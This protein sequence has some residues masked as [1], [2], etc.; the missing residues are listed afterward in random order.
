[1]PRGKTST[2][3]EFGLSGKV[4][5]APLIRLRNSAHVVH[6]LSRLG[7][8]PAPSPAVS[9]APD[10][11]LWRQ[12]RDSPVV[13]RVLRL[14]AHLH[15]AITL[16][17]DTSLWNGS[18]V[19]IINRGGD[20]GRVTNLARSLDRVQLPYTLASAV[21]KRDE[22]Q[23]IGPYARIIGQ[24][25]ISRHLSGPS[26]SSTHS[27]LGG[28]GGGLAFAR[29]VLTGQHHGVGNDRGGGGGGVK[30]GGGGGGDSSWGGG[31]GAP[32]QGPQH[33]MLEHLISHGEAWAHVVQQGIPYALI[34]DDDADIS[35]GRFRAEF[36]RT[37]RQLKL[38]LFQ[39]AAQAVL[40]EE[41]VALMHG[42]GYDLSAARRGGSMER[43]RESTTGAEDA[44]RDGHS[45]VA[46]GQRGEK[47]LKWGE[48]A[49]GNGLGG[50]GGGGRSGS[51]GHVGPTGHAGPRVHAS[52]A[53]ARPNGN[54]HVSSAEPHGHVGVATTRASAGPPPGPPRESPGFDV[55][56]LGRYGQVD[57][58]DL[59]SIGARLA[60]SHHG[61]TLF[62]YLVTLEGAKRLLQHMHADEAGLSRV[63]WG[64]P[65]L[66]RL[67]ADPELATL[68]PGGTSAC[69]HRSATWKLHMERC[70][71][72]LRTSIAPYCG[73]GASTFY[74]K[75][76]PD[77]PTL[78]HPSNPPP[79]HGKGGKAGTALPA[80]TA[81]RAIPVAAEAVRAAG[82]ERACALEPPG[83]L[84]NGHVGTV[85]L[86]AP[87]FPLE[88]RGGSDE[89]RGRGL[90]GHSTAS[91]EDQQHRMVPAGK[92]DASQPGDDTHQHRD[93][94]G[95]SSALNCILMCQPGGGGRDGGGVRGGAGHQKVLPGLA[96]FP[97]EGQDDEGRGQVDAS[98]RGRKP[99]L[100]RPGP[101]GRAGSRGDDGNVSD[102]SG[103][104]DQSYDEGDD[105]EGADE[106]G[107]EGPDD[108]IDSDSGTAGVTEA[109]SSS[110][111]LSSAK[112]SHTRLQRTAA[113]G[114]GPGPWDTRRTG[115]TWRTEGARPSRPR[116]AGGGGIRSSTRS[117]PSAPRVRPPP[118]RASKA[119][120]DNDEADSGSQSRGSRSVFQVLR[121]SLTR[122]GGNKGAMGSAAAATSQSAG[123]SDMRRRASRRLA[124]VDELAYSDVATWHQQLPERIEKWR[125]VY[126][127]ALERSP[128]RGLKTSK[129]IRE[130]GFEGITLGVAVDGK[131]GSQFL[132]Y[133]DAGMLPSDHKS[134][135]RGDTMS[136][137]ELGCMGSHFGIWMDMV[138]RRVPY[139]VVF[140]D[141]VMF[142]SDFRAKFEKGL[143]ELNDM[144]REKQMHMDVC[145]MHRFGTYTSSL[146]VPTLFRDRDSSVVSSNLAW[147]SAAYIITLH[148]AARMLTE[149]KMDDPVDMLWWKVDN[150]RVFSFKENIVY[151]DKSIPSSLGHKHIW[152]RKV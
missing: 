21:H 96:A 150:L 30:S 26:S 140:E 71:P 23:L 18:H 116:I 142:P 126:M 50:G 134:S 144:L 72:S 7:V 12:L 108:S 69:E 124:T 123:A 129:R 9:P 110:L 95:C 52:T 118:R 80:G 107:D 115:G 105:A 130:A 106:G 79:P 31:E 138:A 147:G 35:E 127:V 146:E 122:W 100:P 98:G 58:M 54:G 3:K 90:P 81:G 111:T 73:K 86:G 36:G 112:S 125:E 77:D 44:R 4:R 143:E 145:L 141:D 131:D 136:A 5:P 78:P 76:S 151:D 109:S 87:A 94:P 128:E 2:W 120:A 48:H 43:Q 66:H 15:D 40:W 121:D 56:V 114:S 62:A 148:G 82:E 133:E 92:K 88:P 74:V 33:A 6:G 97:D 39:R 53:T 24:R 32:S 13:R 104:E 25:F 103:D 99:P 102:S 22:R 55:L 49:E 68:D 85:V 42:P 139:A 63:F 34:F 135:V 8:A 46:S 11:A 70:R 19:F 89:E 64:M 75:G 65:A 45:G 132:Q 51:Y 149:A 47:M 137:G 83:S 17:T 152:R 84:G 57:K 38:Y 101:T 10:S 91:G 27:I 20:K 1:M 60:F 61:A 59:H 93:D 29:S 119:E 28:I 67:V 16:P 117:Q 37:M 113:R 41:R 14:S